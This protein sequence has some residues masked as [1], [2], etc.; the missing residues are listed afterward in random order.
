MRSLGLGR[1]SQSFKVREDTYGN[2]DS[3]V[4]AAAENPLNPRYSLVVVAGM[5]PAATL[6]TA[7]K[8]ATRELQPAE[9]VVFPPNGEGLALVVPAKKVA[10]QASTPAGS[11]GGR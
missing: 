1:N 4:I 2:A 10:R 6:R 3:A 7:P 9:V 11:A 8:L 5:G